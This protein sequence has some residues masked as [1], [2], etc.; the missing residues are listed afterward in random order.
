MHLRVDGWPNQRFALLFVDWLTAEPEVRA[1]YVNVKRAA[2]ERAGGD[3]ASY[4]DAKEP[5]FSDAYRR[6][7]AWA[8]VTG[9]RP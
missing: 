1:E 4:V 3:I 8:D 7:W 6:A 9:W 5:W 2:A